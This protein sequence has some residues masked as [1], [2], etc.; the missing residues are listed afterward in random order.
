MISYGQIPAKIFD[1][2]AMGKPIL[3]TNV[4]E[5]P[6]IIQDCGWIAKPDDARELAVKI[7]YIL[8]HPEEAVEK[9]K[10]ARARFDRDYGWAILEKKILRVF[11]NLHDPA[12]KRF[13]N[14]G[15]TRF[16]R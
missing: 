10:K 13:Q 5:I 15:S 16:Q 14:A 7:R 6:R 11:S 2:M 3:S 8:N 4:S 9:G 12:L 1:A